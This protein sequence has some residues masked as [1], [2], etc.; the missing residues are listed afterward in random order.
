M[1]IQ[2]LVDR[3]EE[4]IDEGRHVWLTKLTLI[5]EERA[6]EVI[7]Q[8]RIS[9]PEEI[10]KA[11]RILTQRDRLMAQAGEEA[12]RVVDQAK[13]K[14]EMLIQRDAIT[15]A[16]Q[17]RAAQIIEQARLDAEQIRSDADSYVLDVLREFES[18]LLKTMNIVRNGINKIVQ[19]REI[20]RG[21]SNVSAAVPATTPAPSNPVTPISTPVPAQPAAQPPSKPTLKPTD[22]AAKVDVP[23]DVN[24]DAETS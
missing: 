8:M 2:H 5:D 13:D 14:A 20:M 3:L 17:N 18:H 21:G 22:I 12:A 6:L 15:Q 23:L 9:V 10:D 11:N 19:D 7:D 24:A 16:A 4:L 1:D